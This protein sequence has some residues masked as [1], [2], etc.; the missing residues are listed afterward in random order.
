LPLFILE[1]FKLHHYR[2][3]MGG[4]GEQQIPLCPSGSSE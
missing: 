1:Q 3:V 4:G 2:M